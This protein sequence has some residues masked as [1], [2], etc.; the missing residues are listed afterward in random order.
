MQLDA[1]QQQFREQ[2]Q[3]LAQSGSQLSVFET[4]IAQ[5]ISS[6]GQT[7]A[8]VTGPGNSQEQQKIWKE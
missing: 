1:Q 6:R 2:Q 3:Q 5:A 7:P 4:A 8:P